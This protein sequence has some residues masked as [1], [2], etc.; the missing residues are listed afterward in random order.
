MPVVT[1]VMPVR[2]GGKWLLEAVESV[3]RQSLLDWECVIVDDGS[4][5]DSR[6]AAGSVQDDRVLLICHGTNRGVSAALNT[7]IRAASGR[8][9]QMLAADDLIE[10]EKLERQA[11]FL[12]EHLDVG[13]V[14][15]EARYFDDGRPDQLRRNLTS[16]GDWMPRL[17]GGR[18]VMLPAFVRE[19]IFPI[20]AGLVR[21]SVFGSVGLHDEK[22]PSHEDYDWCLRCADAGVRFAHADMPGTA[23]RIRC[24]PGSLIQ[25]RVRM[26]ETK[27]QVWA[28]IEPQLDKETRKIARGSRA[29]T[30]LLLAREDVRESRHLRASG[31][32][33]KAVAMHPGV[34]G[35]ANLATRAFAASVSLWPRHS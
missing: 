27:L 29:W 5:D 26:L 8:Y 7:G 23:V 6:E 17:S 28:K 18:D 12:D 20:P 14:Y 33:V 25:N 31:R 34:R 32:L 9:V 19:N 16:D 13:I 24:H 10:E 11:T 1:V 4:T 35:R 3:Q 22:L 30:L 2:N 21:R 15:G